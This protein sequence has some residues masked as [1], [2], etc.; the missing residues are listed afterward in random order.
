MRTLNEI[1][2]ALGRGLTWSGWRYGYCLHLPM[3][4]GITGARHDGP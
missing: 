1:L 4:L 3:P 2:G